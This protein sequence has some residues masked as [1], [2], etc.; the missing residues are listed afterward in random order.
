MVK[1]RMQ[2]ISCMFIITSILCSCG[3]RHTTIDKIVGV[4]DPIVK[5]QNISSR[6]AV[7]DPI[8]KNQNISS[9]VKLKMN[10][11]EPILRNK[12]K[13]RF[14]N[15]VDKIK[16]KLIKHDKKPQYSPVVSS[17]IE[18]KFISNMKE[19]CL[20]LTKC[21]LT[22]ALIP[23]ALMI[24]VLHIYLDILN[25]AFPQPNQDPFLKITWKEYIEHFVEIA[26]DR[27][28]IPYKIVWG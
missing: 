9:S 5:N 23:P 18:K 28:L 15:T 19:S 4:E 13:N 12:Y 11:D 1:K 8:V 24:P 21:L 17:E 25:I 26:V 7:E 27:M 10:Q 14:N 20:F 2:G 6:Q 3:Q 16:N 22:V